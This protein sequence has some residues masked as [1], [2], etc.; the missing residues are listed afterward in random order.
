[1]RSQGAAA[2]GFAPMR[3]CGNFGTCTMP[4]PDLWQLLL[5]LQDAPNKATERFN[6][7]YTLHDLDLRFCLEGEQLSFFTYEER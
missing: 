7:S 1:M 4:T 3:P 5:E 2:A 6:R